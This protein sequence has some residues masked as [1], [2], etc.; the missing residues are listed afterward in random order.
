MYFLFSSLDW[1]SPWGALLI[2]TLF[3]F[4]FLLVWP[5][6]FLFIAFME[7][8]IFLYAP[9]FLPL[10]FYPLPET[11]CSQFTLE[12]S[13]LTSSST[14]TST[15]CS[16]CLLSFT[17]ICFSSKSPS[18]HQLCNFRQGILCPLATIWMWW[19]IIWVEVV[20]GIVFFVVCSRS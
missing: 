7:L 14:E 9:L 18:N 12:L 1:H 8:Y 5:I 16:S 4:F 15:L 11:P 6:L 17:S 13:S 19:E 2:T 3:C 10:A 20:F